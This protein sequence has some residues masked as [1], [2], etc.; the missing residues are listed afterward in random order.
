MPTNM[1]AFSERYQLPVTLSTRDRWNLIVIESCQTVTLPYALQLSIGSRLCLTKS[2]VGW[3]L[4]ASLPDK[5]RQFLMNN[6]RNRMQD[7]KGRMQLRIEEAINHVRE[8]GFCVSPSEAGQPM[9]MIAAPV[10]VPGHAPLALCCMGPA[11][12]MN[13]NRTT[14]ELGPALTYLAQEIQHEGLA[15]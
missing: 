6:A 9:T 13:R 10:K 12:W 1:R 4:L 7:D 11:T 8:K 3:A 2:A 15:S 14:R 5:E